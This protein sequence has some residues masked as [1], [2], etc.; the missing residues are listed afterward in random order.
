MPPSPPYPHSEAIS[1][2]FRFLPSIFIFFVSLAYLVAGKQKFAD[3]SCLICFGFSICELGFSVFSSLCWFGMWIEKDYRWFASLCLLLLMAPF[4]CFMSMLSFWK[5][6]WFGGW[7]L[8]LSQPSLTQSCHASP[9]HSHGLA[10]PQDLRYTLLFLCCSI[11]VLKF[12]IFFFSV[13]LK[14]VR[15]FWL[16]GGSLNL[17]WW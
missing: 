16:C 14:F 9:S 11:F 13:S 10:L 3:F 1:S 6:V 8:T 5:V 7:G 17:L 15:R 4:L 2:I 12:W